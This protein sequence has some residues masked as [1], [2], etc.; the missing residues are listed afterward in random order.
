MYV[1]V[2]FSRLREGKIFVWSC[3][4]CPICMHVERRLDPV[5]SGEGVRVGEAIGNMVKFVAPMRAWRQAR[6]PS[7]LQILDPSTNL[8][9]TSALIT[10]TDLH[11]IIHAHD[12]TASFGGISRRYFEG[13]GGE[14]L[15]GYDHGFN[16][17]CRPA[18]RC[19]S[20]ASRD[21]RLDEATP[22]LEFTTT[23]RGCS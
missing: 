5:G 21:A 2:L 15:L 17:G 14:H 18:F 1:S 12:H 20:V 8:S 16:C 19:P 11:K 6:L 23:G 22:T 9:I 13:H 7:R 3:C 10:N 4:S